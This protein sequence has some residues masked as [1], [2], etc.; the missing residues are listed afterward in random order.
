[1]ARVTVVMNA[2]LTAVGVA[3]LIRAAFG[4][5]SFWTVI[6]S[7]VLVLS[8]G[9]KWVLAFRRRRARADGP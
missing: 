4:G 6:I 8:A 1:M 9:T 3:I 2:L 7:V 5:I